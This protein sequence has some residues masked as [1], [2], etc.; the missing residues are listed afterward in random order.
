MNDGIFDVA[1]H[2]AM[3]SSALIRDYLKDPWRRR[4]LLAPDRYEYPVPGGGYWSGAASKTAPPGSDVAILDADLFSTGARRS[5]VLIPYTRGLLPDVTL[6][7]AVCAATNDWL[8]DTWLSRSDGSGRFLGTIRV[9]PRDPRAAVAE[10]ERWASDSQMVQ[11][12]VPL[13]S[14]HP[15]GQRQFEPVWQAAAAHRLPVAIISDDGGGIE[16]APTTSGYAAYFSE[17]GVLMPLNGLHHLLSFIMEGVLERLPDLKL[18]F[19]DGAGD[20]VLPLFWRTDKDWRAIKVE[21]PWVKRVPTE[22]VLA[23]CRFCV[24]R[25]EGPTSE[26]L[27]SGWF[28]ISR[29]AQ[30]FLYGSRY[31]RW[32]YFPAQDASALFPTEI[33]SRIMSENARDLY[34]RS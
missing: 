28:D 1:V 21:V 22:Y 34:S 7:S 9:D 20:V 8:R 11:I 25:L 15:Y 6:S 30:L 27:R 3:A 24:S 4:G 23:N 12:A 26:A 10:I 14:H 16:F 31:P 19:V 18:V 33:R 13:E 29:A 2:P 5:A 32:N 17:Y